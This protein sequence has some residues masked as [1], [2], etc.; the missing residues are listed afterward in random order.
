MKERY[1]GKK[2][3]VMNSSGTKF[4]SFSLC[5]QSFELGPSKIYGLNSLIKM[6]RPVTVD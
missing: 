3:Q 4:V 2:K 1:D 5:G 6:C